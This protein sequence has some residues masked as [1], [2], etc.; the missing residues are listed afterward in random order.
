MRTLNLSLG[1]ILFGSFCA[2]T[3]QPPI[4]EMEVLLNSG[5]RQIVSIGD[6]EQDVLRRMPWNHSS[7]KFEGQAKEG[8]EFSHALDYTD[9]GAKI[10]FNKKRVAMIEIREP[11]RGKVQGRQME[12]F[13]FNPLAGQT[14]DEVLMRKL[15]AP[16]ARAS[17]GRFGSESLYY[18][19]G[20]VLFNRR[21]PYQLSIYQDSEIRRAR[22]RIFSR[23]ITEKTE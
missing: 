5:I 12:L 23:E 19:W 4:P 3:R 15:G 16:I 7:E 9:V 1:I 11:F 6:L 8:G 17:G 13:V 2:C 20:D 10:Y 22:Q 14:W 18:D 21:R